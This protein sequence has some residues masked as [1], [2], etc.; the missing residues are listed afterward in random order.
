MACSHWQSGIESWD[1]RRAAALGGDETAVAQVQADLRCRILRAF[2][3]WG[4]LESFEAKDML[5]YQHSEPTSDKR[6]A[7]V[8][9]LTLTPL[10]LI[11]R[12]AAL[13]RL[14]RRWL[15][16]R[17]RPPSKP[18]GAMAYLGCCHNRPSPSRYHPSAHRRTTCGRC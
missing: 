6:G 11:D 17:N 10:E 12:I 18:A 9:E 7:K 5:T 2:V 3:G 8:Y 4:L 16:Q 1:A 13:E 15:H 14:L